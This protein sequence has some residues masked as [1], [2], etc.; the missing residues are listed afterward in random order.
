[1]KMGNYEKLIMDL[2]KGDT[3]KQK[4]ENIKAILEDLPD[5]YLVL[6]ATKNYIAELEKGKL[7][8]NL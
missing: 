5:M 7:I 1:M 8:K 6:E 4:Y 2:I 3:P